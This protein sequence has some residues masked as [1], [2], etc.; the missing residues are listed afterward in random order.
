MET[1]VVVLSKN[2]LQIRLLA[3]KYM[4]VSIFLSYC[5]MA[6]NTEKKTEKYSMQLYEI[7]AGYTNTSY[8]KHFTFYFFQK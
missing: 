6:D 7:S 5:P 4:S 8:R 3:F 1:M 2:K